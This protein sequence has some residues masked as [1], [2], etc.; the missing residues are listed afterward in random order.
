MD[1]HEGQCND[2]QHPDPAGGDG[3]LDS[4]QRD[5]LLMTLVERLHEGTSPNSL[6]AQASQ[7]VFDTGGRCGAPERCHAAGSASDEPLNAA[8]DSGQSGAATNG[9]YRDRDV[10]TVAGDIRGGSRA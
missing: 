1:G 2:G 4:G 5:M 8:G 9:G 10:S 6:L 3:V 7:M